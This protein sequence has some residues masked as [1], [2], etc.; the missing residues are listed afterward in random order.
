MIL[1]IETPHE[2]AYVEFWYTLEKGQEQTFYQ[3]YIADSIHDI[4]WELSDVSEEINRYISYNL[5]E[6]GDRIISME[7]E[8]R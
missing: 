1:Q 6:I 8:V 3:E 7:K 4:E 5:D 2:E